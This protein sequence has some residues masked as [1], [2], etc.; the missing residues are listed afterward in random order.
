[1]WVPKG[2]GVYRDSQDNYGFNF[3]PPLPAV[4]VQAADE[5]GVFFA[6]MNFH[7]VTAKI[8]YWDNA[9][10]ESINIK[11]T[12]PRNPGPIRYFFDKRE[13]LSNSVVVP[14][15]QSPTKFLEVGKTEVTFD[16]Y[17]LVTSNKI[18]FAKEA[19]N[20]WN[21][22]KPVGQVT[23]YDAIIYCNLRSEMEGLEKVYSYTDPV[24]GADNSQWKGRCIRLSNL[25]ADLT[26]SGYRLPTEEE[27]MSLYA[28]P[29]AGEYYWSSGQDPAEYA[30]YGKFW[31][32]NTKSVGL[33]LPNAKG[34]YD[35]SGNAAEFVWASESGYPES[36]PTVYLKGGSV[37][38]EPP[39][40]GRSS[41][42]TRHKD[43]H[44]PAHSIR[45]VRT[46]PGPLNSAIIMRLVNQ[47]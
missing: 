2:Q 12:I 46:V 20:P 13:V 4:N 16:D 37:G 6:D 33:K 27:W 42:I 24:Y 38:L 7:T 39:S 25:S 14:V 29:Y 44:D 3:A 17:Y 31:E 43:E 15:S 32:F 10:Y 11:G 36:S 21:S 26:K 40:L 28:P 47:E 18:P 30:W 1:M 19:W 34:L 22:R 23:W 5:N 41:R 9:W 45:V 35:L 8:T